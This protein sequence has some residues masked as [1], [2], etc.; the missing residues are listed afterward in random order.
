MSVYTMNLLNNHF[1]EIQIKYSHK[2]PASERIRISSSTDV[3]DIALKVW[4]DGTIDHC[5][6]FMVLLI[7]R[8]N[9][10]LGYSMISIGGLAGTVADPKKIF[11]TALKASASSII[12]VHNHPSGN[13]EPSDADHKLT[14]KLKSAGEF[15]D[16][17]VLD[18]LIITPESYYSFADENMM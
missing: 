12:L 10:V 17:T 1:A 13:K 5:E 3:H 14:R 7:N 6:S 11:Q 2:I 4:P 16:L 8:A 15:L 18:H 9:K